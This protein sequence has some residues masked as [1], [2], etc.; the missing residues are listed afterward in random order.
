MGTARQDVRISLV[1]LA[2]LLTAVTIAPQR[3]WAQT[4]A[5]MEYDRQ[6]REY[7]RQQEQQRQ[8]QQRQQQQMNENARRQQEQMKQLNA[9]P[10]QSPTPG[11]GPT[12]RTPS[13]PPGGQ[14]L[15]EARQTWLKRP[16]LPPERNPLLGRWTRPP[17]GKEN[18]SDPFAALQALAKGGLCE[19]FFGGGTFEFRATTLV[20]FDAR[21]SEQELDKVE[22]RGDAKQVVVL[23]KTTVRLMVFDVEGPNRINWSGQNCALVRVGPSSRGAPVASTAPLQN[24]AP[25]VSPESSKATTPSSGAASIAR[26]SEGRAG[27]IASRGTLLSLVAGLQY[28]SGKYFPLAGTTFYVLKENLD[29][30]LARGGVQA[31]SGVSLLRAWILACETQQTATCSQGNRA[32]ETNTVATLRTDLQGRAELG[33]LNAGTYYVYGGNQRYQQHNVLWNVRV[34]VREGANNAVKLDQANLIS[35]N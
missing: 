28:P 23:P 3:A 12:Q 25:A 18:L 14:A 35:I 7:W 9:P 15:E 26:A 13:G 24:A 8:E 17:T 5:Q 2:A 6:Q 22:Y 32:F 20:G 31:P 19:L 10:G 30:A 29:A 33:T 34:D 21:T 11:Q 1:V 27:S 16:P 4:P